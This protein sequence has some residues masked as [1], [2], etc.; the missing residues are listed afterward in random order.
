MPR[1]RL[2]LEERVLEI[3]CLY[4]DPRSSPADTVSVP[5]LRLTAT[6]F[7]VSPPGTTARGS[8]A[9]ALIDT[10]SWIS[11]V[12]MNTWQEYDKAGLLEHLPFAGNVEQTTFV[13]GYE[14]KY[15]LGRLWIVLADATTT[16]IVRL[17]AVP[18]IVQLLQRRTKLLKHYP[19]IL[20]LPL[21]VLDGRKLTRE[22]V[23]VQ[24]APL[25]TDRGR[26]YGQEWY[27][28]SA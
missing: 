8:S 13:G 9:T 22:V 24:S 27:L 3:P 23:P 10:G 11:V 1:I 4:N 5:L 6:A 21:G 18:V 28:E 20:G 2:R 26:Q 14:C 16:G 25:T 12:E 15:R 19:L 7:I 17:P